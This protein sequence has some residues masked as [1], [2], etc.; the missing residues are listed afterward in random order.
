MRG[1]RS[2]G[3]VCF[4][5]AGWRSLCG[6][7]PSALPGISPSRGE[8][9]NGHSLHF[10]SHRSPQ[11]GARPCTSS[12]SPL[13]GEMSGRTEGGAVRLSGRPNEPKW[14]HG[15]S[16]PLAQYRSL[17]LN[18]I[19]VALSQGSIFSSMPTRRLPPTKK[20]RIAPRLLNQ[21][22]PVALSSWRA[23]RRNCLPWQRRRAHRRRYAAGP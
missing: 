3:C 14:G 5:S 18:R 10:T 20:P 11:F 17:N 23:R 7:P 6:S 22:R 9:G 21:K 16:N 12:I 13:E 8:I 15:K 1:L 19:A 2:R 4:S